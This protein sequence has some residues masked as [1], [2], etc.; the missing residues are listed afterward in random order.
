[1]DTLV[2]V[3]IHDAK[4][5][6]NALGVWLVQ[7]REEFSAQTAGA[8][9]AALRQ[10]EALTDRLS[11][12][13]VELLALYRAG[14]GSLRL[15]ID[16]HRLDEFL[17]DVMNELSLSRSVE[18]HLRIE[19][20][21]AATATIDEWAFDAYLVKFVLLDALRNALRHARC[22]VRFAC[23]HEAAGGLRFSIEDDGG[24][25]PADWL[26]AVDVG[27]NDSLAMRESGSG[28]GLR[29]ACLIAARHQ[30][31]GAQAGRQGH[32]QL[33]NDGLGQGGARFV[34][35]LP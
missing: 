31:P 3:A 33:S 25:Y 14:E 4:N 15:T 29:F 5:A 12:Q 7:A 22:T 17:A 1:M 34:L 19:T 6:L 21:F 13:M 9:C 30:L 11:G 2:A 26:R 23:F 18:P 28:L 20:D 24:G 35:S 16:D 8:D 10:A 32:L 27:E